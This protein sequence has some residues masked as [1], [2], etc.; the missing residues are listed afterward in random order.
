MLKLRDKFILNYIIIGFTIVVISGMSYLVSMSKVRDITLKN[1]DTD[2]TSLLNIQKLN[3][4]FDD[5]IKIYRHISENSDYYLLYLYFKIDTVFKENLDVLIKEKTNL[6]KDQFD[7]IKEKNENL[8][9][10]IL[11][12]Q[13]RF[14]LIRYNSYTLKTR[15]FVP[16]NDT[17]KNI[18]TILKDLG[19]QNQN[20]I[21]NNKLKID[22]T[23]GK[24]KIIIVL[25][26]FF[27][28]FLSIF[29]GLFYS[30]KMIQSLSMSINVIQKVAQKD[31]TA[32][33]DLTNV[34]DDEVGLL[35]NSINQLVVNLKNITN[36]L[37]DV[38]YT[39]NSNIIR[40]SNSAETISD[41]ARNQKSTLIDTSTA[42]NELSSSI[43]QVSTNASAVRNIT[44][45]TNKEAIESGDSVKKLVAGMSAISERTE[46]IVEIIDVIDDIAEQTNLLALNAAIE[47]ARAGVHGRGFAVVAQEIRKLAE[48]S[49]QSTKNIARLIKDSVE[50][51]TEGDEL[52]QKAGTAIENILSKI[53]NINLLIHNIS[54]ATSDQVNQSK[55][56]VNSIQ[57]LNQITQRNSSAADDLLES[58]NQ[59][60]RQADNL[61]S[62]INEFQLTKTEE[63]P[64]LE[65]KELPGA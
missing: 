59:L 51:I 19:N 18:Q 34:P 50:V 9:S 29:A 26:L 16:I 60:K 25:I 14:H 3:S 55:N 6:F 58:I 30:Q 47:A 65:I 46:K 5:K 48:K 43:S 61:H 49:A 57:Y 24:T 12:L 13:K 20:L 45:L 32:Q 64:V 10:L 38:I 15:Y 56:I 36:I 33:I 40:I 39:L 21:K 27:I 23:Y 7:L 41:G 28:I 11:Q 44:E 62:T 1:Y 42:M 53:Q 4:Y 31:L 37:S 8:N 17:I 54:N 35:V 52:S 63:L 2:Y 22:A